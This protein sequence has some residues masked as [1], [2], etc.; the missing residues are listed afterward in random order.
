MI[1]RR[2]TIDDATYIVNECTICDKKDTEV[3]GY[4]VDCL[5]KHN[6]KVKKHAV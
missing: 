6:K 1:A 5:A 3:I 4:C 2:I